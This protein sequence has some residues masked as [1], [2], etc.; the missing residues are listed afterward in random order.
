M[1][2]IFMIS[3]KMAAQGLLLFMTSPTKFFEGWSWL[4]LI[5]LGLVL[6]KNLKFY[7]SM[8][9]W[10]K[11]KVFGE[12]FSGPKPTFVENSGKKLVRGCL[13]SLPP[14]PRP[15]LNRVK[16]LVSFFVYLNN[17]LCFI[18]TYLCGVVIFM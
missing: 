6:S 15:N 13:F 18:F 4:K 10:L 2:I 1:V 5:N 11:I 7:T 14:P 17:L 8:A 3:A 9:K 16:L 12:M